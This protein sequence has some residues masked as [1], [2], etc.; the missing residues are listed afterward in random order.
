[1][2]SY[3]TD[4]NLSLPY[5]FF[6]SNKLQQDNQPEMYEIVITF[7]SLAVHV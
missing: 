7:F 2:W 4:A 5:N 6:M 3:F 1:M